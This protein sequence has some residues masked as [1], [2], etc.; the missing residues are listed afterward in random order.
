MY[1][2]NRLFP[3]TLFDHLKRPLTAKTFLS[4]GKDRETHLHLQKLPKTF[5]KWQI[6]GCGDIRLQ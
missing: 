1:V 3:K 4:G 5:E 2:L 6:G